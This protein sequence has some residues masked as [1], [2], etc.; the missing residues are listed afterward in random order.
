MVATARLGTQGTTT[1]RNGL[2]ASLA[3]NEVATD[4]ASEVGHD[5]PNVAS[6]GHVEATSAKAVTANGSTQA[7]ATARTAAEVAWSVAHDAP[8]PAPA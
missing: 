4:V 3:L 1:G 2:V 6:E 5:V 8:R 7:S